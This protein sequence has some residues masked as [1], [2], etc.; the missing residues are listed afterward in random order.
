MPLKNN[1]RIRV[2]VVDDSSTV[3]IAATKVFGEGFDVLIAIDGQDGLDVVE[4]DPLIQVIFTD[5]MMPEMDGFE[6]LKRLKTHKDKSV[7]NLPIIVMT[8][9][10][11][12]EIAKQKA[13]GLGA[14]DFITKPFNATDIRARALSYAKLSSTTKE[15]REKATIDDL[16]GLLNAKGFYNQLDKEIAFTTRHHYEI[17]AMNV[18]IDNY[19][20]LFI[21]MGRQGTE[22]LI[23]H[24][25]AIVVKSLRKEDT[26]ARVGLACFCI[27]MPLVS[28]KNAMEMAN[29]VCQNI[30]NLKVILQGKRLKL[31]VSAGISYFE[32]ENGSH[33]K[34]L[35]NAAQHALE[36]ANTLGQ[37]QI[38]LLTVE[39]HTA[40]KISN[41]K[42]VSIDELIDQISRGDDHL[43]AA[44]LNDAIDQLAPLIAL[45]S[46]EQK[47]RIL[48]YR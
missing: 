20:D 4:N 3:R 11:N 34:Q 14:T 19:K 47:Q 16:T 45:L 6:L 18:E 8:G 25:G 26:I 32:P 23:K 44:K 21:S 41:S 28:K 36:H 42:S 9:A 12:P 43:V 30:E 24:V 10:E 40:K 2:L 29:K 46:H 35:I 27:S 48:T 5:L 7:R 1:Q 33:P 17:S 37:S 15:L 13:L 38:Y 31:T 22:K 39:D